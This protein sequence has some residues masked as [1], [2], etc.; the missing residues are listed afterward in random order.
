MT[1]ARFSAGLTETAIGPSIGTGF[2]LLE[3]AMKARDGD[4][5]AAQSLSIGLQNTIYI[6]L[7]YV[8]P[9]LDYLWINSIREAASPGYLKRQETRRRKEYGQKSFVPRTA[10]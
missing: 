1:K 3:L 6:N 4:A 10:N 8:R 5:S 2:D 7:F 9:A